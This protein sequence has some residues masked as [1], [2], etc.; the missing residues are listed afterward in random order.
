MIS[1]GFIGFGRMG[2]TH[3]SILNSHPGVHIQSVCDA[4]STMMTVL[5]SLAPIQTYSDAGT[6]VEKEKLDCVV[7]STPSDSHAE[8]INTSLANNLHVFSEK[9]FVLSVADGEGILSKLKGK[10]L[11]NQVGYVNRFNEVFVELKGH[12]N[13]GLIGD[14]KSFSSEMYAPTVLKDTKGSW[15]SKKHSGGG[16][17]YELGCHCI[18]LSVYLFGQPDRVAGSTVLSVFSSDVE[19]IVSTTLI[20]DGRYSGSIAVNWSDESCRKPANIVKAFG[21]K[22]KIIADKHAY[23]V[24]LKEDRPNLGFKKGWNTRYI[25]EFAK[26]VRFYLRGN[27]FTRQLDYFVDCIDSQAKG[28]ISSFN[29]AAK[30]DA[31]IAEIM[32]DSTGTASAGSAHLGLG[33]TIK[34]ASFFRSF[35]K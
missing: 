5:K 11:V 33:E 8:L 4:S 18:D 16:C 27:E 14:I 12:I 15:R 20:Y 35:L 26:P 17:L 22:G 31:I 29:E 10:S 32:R 13:S 7:I 1:V 21:T 9:P 3:F 28:N 23:R 30:T 19:D 34:H 6:M 2:L 24:F 25:T